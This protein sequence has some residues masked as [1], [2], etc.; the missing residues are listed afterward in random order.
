M[1][2]KK[3]L[4]LASTFPRWENDSTSPFVF[5]LE[6]RLTKDFEIHVLAPHC[7]GAKKFEI[8]DGLFVHRFQYWW[9][10]KLQKLSYEGGILPKLKKHPHLIT[11]M[12]TLVISEFFSTIW[13]IKKEKIDLIHVHWV[14][15]FGL[16]ALIAK[17]LFGTPY[18]V[19]SHGSDIYGLRNQLFVKL[20]KIFFDNAKRVIVVSSHLKK[21]VQKSITNKPS[22]EIISMGVDSQKFNPNKKD[23]YLKKDLNINGPF[24]LFVGRLV[25][26]KGVSYLIEAMPEIVAAYPS[27]KLV[28]V[29]YGPLEDELKD[30]TRKLSIQSN[31]IFTGPIHNSQL[32]AYYATA[33]I[34]ISPSIITSE[35]QTEGF[36]LT[37]V[38][39]ALSG[40]VPIGTNVGGIPDIIQDKKTGILV[41]QKNSLHIS[42]AIIKLLGN[43]NLVIQIKQNARF[44]LT[45]EFDWKIIANKYKQEYIYNVA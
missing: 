26:V 23:P 27:A 28:V 8:M 22:I 36:G 2:K 13:L 1:A 4:V 16:I 34:F 40:S 18:I 9:P 42:D 44:K 43:H 21:E 6:R 35:K 20:K 39:A 24:L 7:A 12:F 33:D 19:T 10:E 15:P 30:L 31:V 32:P 17:M 41:E 38:E 25:A 5:E 29:G 45:Q 3:I 14:I 11:Q 37:F